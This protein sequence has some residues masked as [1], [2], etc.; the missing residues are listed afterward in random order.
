MEV[1]PAD[2]T[3]RNV[4]RLTTPLFGGGLVEA[5]PDS[6]IIGLQAAQPAAIRGFVSLVPLIFPNPK[7]P[8]ENIGDLR[9]GRFGWKAGIATVVQF[10]A[11]AYSNEMG[12]T[13]QSCLRG[14]SITAFAV[15][16]APNALAVPSATVPD[17]CDDLAPRNSAQTAA[18]IGLP[19][20]HGMETDDIVG[21]CA[22]GRTAVQ[23]DVANFTT[24]VTFLAPPPR[25]FSDQVSI[26]R[27]QPLFTQAGCAGCHVDT[28]FHTPPT[29]ANGVPGNFAFNP[30]SDFL[31][32]D[33]GSLGDMIGSAP[34][35]DPAQGMGDSVAV[36]RRMRTA[37][38]W[39]LRFRNHLLHDGRVA[40]VASAVKAHDGQGLAARNAFNALSPADQH[41]LVQFVRSL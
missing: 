9:V 22:D 19:G 15:E 38:L 20:P 13:T 39:G 33:M 25:D 24:F 23:E 10:C 4:G 18:D 6:V 14:T 28:T 37:P 40:D 12:I 41:A 30:Y 7:D 5:I 31:L 26:T 32:H 34:P 2:A 1:E 29:P 36:T 17:G 35:D 27:G 3:V 16:N 8:T 11:D 21:S